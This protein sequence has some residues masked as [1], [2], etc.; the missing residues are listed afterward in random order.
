M[1]LRN[2]VTLLPVRPGSTGVTLEQ[3][4]VYETDC[5]ERPVAD[6]DVVI[7]PRA[8]GRLHG[9]HVVQIP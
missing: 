6:D 4:T 5:H 2:D 8:P 9:V 7:A 3:A 1:G